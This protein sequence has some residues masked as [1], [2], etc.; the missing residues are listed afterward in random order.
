MNADVWLAIGSR[1]VLFGALLFGAAGTWRWPA[2]WAFLLGL[3]TTTILVA[4]W[5]AVHD[6]E[7]LKER[8]KPV[9][10]AEQPVWDRILLSAMGILFLGWLVVMG[11]DAVRF[12]WWDSPLWLRVI[13][14]VGVALGMWVCACTFRANTF[15]APVVKIQRDRAQTVVSTGPYAIVRH[16]L[17]AGLLIVFPSTA[18]M[19]GSL[20]GLAA[21]ILL[22]AGVVIRTA[23]EDHELLRGLDGY[24]EYVQRVRYKLFPL[25]W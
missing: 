3:F 19:L 9:L 16:P 8:M 10:Q 4:R 21:T 22:S 14:G 17:Y 12:H 20:W 24:A 18:I 13:G 5:L 7:L 6:P 15:L 23:K 25:I 1:A 11:V 2:A